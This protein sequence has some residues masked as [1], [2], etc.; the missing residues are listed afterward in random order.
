[1]KPKIKA[2][3]A[4]NQIVP[5]MVWRQFLKEVSTKTLELEITRQESIIAQTSRLLVFLSLI[6]AA[7]Y[8]VL[9]TL[10]EWFEQNSV[11]IGIHYLFITVLLCVSIS[12]LVFSQWRYKYNVLPSV[13]SLQQVSL[14]TPPLSS[15]MLDYWIKYNTNMEKSIF[16]NNQKRCRLLQSATW[17]FLVTIAVVISL[18]LHFVWRV[19]I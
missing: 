3:K 2:R 6:S 19:I 9:P 11:I 8:G 7:V 16:N 13:E 4:D 15:D 5:P 18:L 1:M 14:T 10:L 12:L 17:L